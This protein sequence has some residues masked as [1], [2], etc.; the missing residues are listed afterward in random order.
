MTCCYC[1]AL[2]VAD[3]RTC[4]CGARRRLYVCSSTNILNHYYLEGE[5]WPEFD[6]S[7]PRRSLILTIN[8]YKSRMLSVVDRVTSQLIL[9]TKFL[10]KRRRWPTN[11]VDGRT[12]MRRKGASSFHI[13]QT[14]LF[15]QKKNYARFI[16]TKL[17]R[18][19][20]KGT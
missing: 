2:L 11:F 3:E 20:E 13:Y 19:K 12:K 8:R 7:P 16:A 9:I 6:Y 17:R 4:E 5:Y 15:I 10:P 14:P 18:K 1:F